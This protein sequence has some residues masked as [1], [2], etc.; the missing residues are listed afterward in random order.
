MAGIVH[1]A[2]YFRW[3]EEVE[4]EFFRAFGMSIMDPLPADETGHSPGYLGWPRVSASLRYEAPAHYNEV[5][6]IS[7]DVERIGHKSLS[8]VCE[9]FR[10]GRR[11]AQGRM[12]TACCHCRPDG[13]LKSVEIPPNLRSRLPQPTEPSEQVTNDPTVSVAHRC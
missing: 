1:F 2:N 4:H 7:L 10:D 9:I 8:Y 3:M 6:D 12:K 13:T 5:L 11:I